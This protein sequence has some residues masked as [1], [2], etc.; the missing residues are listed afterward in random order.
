MIYAFDD[1]YTITTVKIVFT[2]K[3]MCNLDNLVAQHAKYK[4]II[5]R[6]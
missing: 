2:K 5:F 1:N 4:K 3:E 6:R